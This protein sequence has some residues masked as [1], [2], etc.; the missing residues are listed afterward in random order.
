MKIDRN[1]FEFYDKLPG[2][3]RM[4]KLDD[5]HENGKK[6]IGMEFLIL[7]VT[8]EVYDVYHL[9]DHHTGSWLNEFI[10]GNRVFIKE[11]K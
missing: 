7:R 10:K 9:A 4:A 5:F 8:K 6:N 11:S 2:G 3:Y 1:G